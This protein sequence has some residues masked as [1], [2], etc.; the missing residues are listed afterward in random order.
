MMDRT[1]RQDA[2]SIIVDDIESPVVYDSANDT[3]TVKLAIYQRLSDMLA[4]TETLIERPVAK[5]ACCNTGL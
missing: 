4:A 3:L 1:I 2:L 5:V